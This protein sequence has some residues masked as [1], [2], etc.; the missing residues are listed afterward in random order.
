MTKEEFIQSLVNKNLA[1]GWYNGEFVTNPTFKQAICS[2]CDCKFTVDT[3]KSV[4]EINHRC[5]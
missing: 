1:F 4:L 3:S 2:I 5:I